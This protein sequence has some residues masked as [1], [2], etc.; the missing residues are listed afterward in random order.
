M[1]PIKKLRSLIQ[2]HLGMEESLAILR[3]LHAAE[4]FHDRIQQSSW[5]TRRQLSPGD[6]AVDY[7]F[8][9]T[10]YNVLSAMK[11]RRILEFGLGQSSKLV[12]QYAA[13]FGAE[14]L[15]CE[16]SD[17]WISFF[18]ES[19]NQDGSARAVE[20][21]DKPDIVDS[22]LGYPMKIKRLPLEKIEVK[23]KL[24]TSYQSVDTVFQGQ[25]F[26]F[27]LVDGPYGEE[28]Y[29]RPQIIPL[30]AENLAGRF[31]ILM[32][33]TQ[34][35]GERETLKE[36]QSILQARG[37]AFETATHC[38]S[39]SHTLIVSPSFRFLCTT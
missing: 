15:T 17:E 37:I 12:H 23:G 14:A 7:G 6:Y 2:H 21:A 36:V 24:T 26:D 1:N 18:F 34:R 28:H 4:V 9:K 33:D 13:H 31:C 8:L 27:I 29:S 10:L 30:A 19:E 39:K 3:D 11:P 38:G 35:Q 5:F 20:L 25:K 16:N 22:S 32:D